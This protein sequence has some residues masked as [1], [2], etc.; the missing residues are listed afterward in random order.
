MTNENPEAISQEGQNLG[1]DVQKQASKKILIVDDD[2]LAIRTAEAILK[3]VH[4]EVLTLNNPKFIFKVIKSEH[5]D[6]VILDIIMRPVDGY[7]VCEE[8][9]KAYGDKIPVLL[10]TAQSYEQDFIQNSYKEFGADDYILK[11]VKSEEFLPKVKALIKKNSSS[12][13]KNQKEDTS[14]VTDRT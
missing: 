9:K 14:S 12:R 2:P 11:P 4:Y 7:A 6:L 5:P 1:Q 10:C 3:K 13:K 8:I